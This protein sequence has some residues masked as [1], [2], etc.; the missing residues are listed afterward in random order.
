MKSEYVGYT[1]TPG[2][3]YGFVIEKNIWRDGIQKMALPHN[4]LQQRNGYVGM[5]Y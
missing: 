1:K 2:F 3:L 5:Q 4:E